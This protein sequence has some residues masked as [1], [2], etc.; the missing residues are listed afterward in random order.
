MK[1][2]VGITAQHDKQ[3]TITPVIMHWP[4]GRQWPVDRVLDVR[5]APSITGGGQGMRYVCRIAN[6][7]VNLFHDDLD[8]KWFVEH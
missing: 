5:M 7:E 3:G 2:Y 8:G 1:T 4:D 6:K